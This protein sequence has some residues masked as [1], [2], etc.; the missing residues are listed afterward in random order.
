MAAPTPQLSFKAVLGERSVRRLW[1][2]HLVSIFGD[3]L[4]VF[5]VFAIVLP[6][7]VISPLAGVFVDKWNV[8]WTMLASDTVRGVL[9]LAMPAQRRAYS[10]CAVSAHCSRCPCETSCGRT[11][12]VRHRCN[13]RC[14][15]ARAGA[16]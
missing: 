8:K 7:A 14:G 9:V 3:F 1:F 5:A 4:A 12:A 2:A 10:P 13:H 6:L 15:N 16:A 11:R